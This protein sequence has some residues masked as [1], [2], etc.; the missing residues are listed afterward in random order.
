MGPLV[1]TSALLAASVAAARRRRAA[2]AAAEA[3]EA[4]SCRSS[5]F[6][7]PSSALSSSP[8]KSSA[9]QGAEPLAHAS[10]SLAFKKASRY[11]C[12]SDS[13]EAEV[14]GEIG[15]GKRSVGRASQLFSP[16]LAVP[17]PLPPPPFEE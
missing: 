1:A 9:A 13:S 4:L 11:A 14:R 7:S 17:L 16:P 15:D 10:A 6:S 5:P 3:A 2:G 8:L 12:S